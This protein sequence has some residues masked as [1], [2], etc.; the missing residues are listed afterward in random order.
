MNPVEYFEPTTVDAAV[1]L[2]KHHDDARCV[3]GGQ[4]L[5]A[6]M[7]AGLVEPR[8]LIGLHRIRGLDEIAIV[9]DGSLWIGAMARHATLAH[10]PRLRGAWNVIREAASV[11]AHPAIRNMGTLGGALCHADPNSDYPAAVVAAQANVEIAGHAGRR[12]VPATE[13]FTGYL[14]TDL[15]AGE[16]LTRVCFPPAPAGVIGVYEKFARVDGDYATVSIALIMRLEH[17][18]CSFARIAL[19]SCAMTPVRVRRAEELLEGSALDADVIA[20]A[21]SALLEACDPIDDVRGSAAYRRTL[22]PRLIHRALGR[23]KRLSERAL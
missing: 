13:F 9:D 3:A 20:A 17:Q 18:R 14:S 22:V 4:T 5:V 6:M 12:I 11:I 21:C 19:G 2:L 8:A 10:E 23:A 1:E 7:N 15:R 16:V